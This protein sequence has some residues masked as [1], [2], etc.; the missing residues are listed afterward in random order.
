MISVVFKILK[1]FD[2]LIFMPLIKEIF[3]NEELA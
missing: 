3:L 2:S 1:I